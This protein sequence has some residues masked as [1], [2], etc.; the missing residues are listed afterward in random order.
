MKIQ[1]II[2]IQNIVYIIKTGYQNTFIAKKKK[3]EE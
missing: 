2:Q 1:V 3:L